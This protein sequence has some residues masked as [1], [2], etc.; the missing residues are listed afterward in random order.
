VIYRIVQESLNNVSKHSGAT[1][2]QISLHYDKALNT[3]LRIVDN[4]CGIEVKR[5]GA[6]FRNYGMGLN[7]IQERAELTGGEFNLLN[8]E[9]VGTII[10]VTWKQNTIV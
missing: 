3:T 5:N 8:N 7:S 6:K 9:P 10:E 4:G 1:E 2:V